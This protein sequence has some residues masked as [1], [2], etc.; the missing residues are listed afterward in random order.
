[1]YNLFC[2][3]KNVSFECFLNH[4]VT[5]NLRK[6]CS[7]NFDLIFF[8]CVVDV[9][10]CLLNSVIER[11]EPDPIIGGINF[12]VMSNFKFIIALRGIAI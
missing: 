3:R 9:I 2:A 10:V 4:I 1:M 11:C 12:C 6:K 8:H 5:K 7:L